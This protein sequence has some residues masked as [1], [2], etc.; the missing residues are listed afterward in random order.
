MYDFA[1]TTNEQLPD[2]S[3]ERYFVRSSLTD[4]IVPALFPQAVLHAVGYPGP[5]FF[6]YLNFNVRSSRLAIHWLKFQRNDLVFVY[7]IYHVSNLDI[8]DRR[9]ITLECHQRP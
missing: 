8:N 6:H 4:W 5:I 1:T 2:I 9:T 3:R 7:R